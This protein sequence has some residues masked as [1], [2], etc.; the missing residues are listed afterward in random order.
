[1][2]YIRLFLVLGLALHKAVWEVMKRGEASKLSAP[3]EPL[4]P[5]KSLLKIVKVVFL[6]F[7]VFQT[8]FLDLFPITSDPG[9]LRTLGIAIY[10]IGLA[11]AITGRVHLGKNWAN[12]EDYQVI[13][14]QGL[15]QSGIYSFIRHPI[16]TGDFLLILGLELALNS[17]LVLMVIPL[18]VVI[19][20]QTSAEE[21]VL[22][23]AFSNYNAYQQ[24]TKKFIPFVI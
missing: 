6:L 18:A 23:R 21:V 15:V 1:M 2:L 16:Y 9:V 8:L 20:R 4:S 10:V 19:F 3:Q 14:G 12:L 17:W 5:L 24:R 7:L 22:S 13:E 11:T